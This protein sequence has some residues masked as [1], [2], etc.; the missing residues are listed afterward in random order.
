MS[1]HQTPIQSLAN[2]DKV[3]ITS[4]EEFVFDKSILTGN[5]ERNPRMVHG[6]PVAVDCHPTFMRTVERWVED[7]DSTTSVDEDGNVTIRANF[8]EPE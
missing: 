3:R 4:Y 5:R 2:G 6:L 8:A 1:W 7:S